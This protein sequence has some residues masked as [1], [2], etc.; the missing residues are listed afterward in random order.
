MTPTRPRHPLSVAAWLLAA[1]LLM[2]CSQ[3]DDTEA[4]FT[5]HSWSFTGFCYTPNWDRGICSIL[6][7]QLGGQDDHILNTLTFQADGRLIIDMPGCTLSADWVADGSDRSFAITNTRVISGSTD[8][9]SPFSRKFLSDLKE[10]VWYRGDSTYLQI[11][12]AEGH[13]YL[14][15]APINPY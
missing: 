5:P 8:K 2:S 6:N 3:A 13:Y 12:E 15:F 11:F 1:M 7:L 9:L 10:A 4:I 14:L